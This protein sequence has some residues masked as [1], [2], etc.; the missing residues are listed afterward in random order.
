VLIIA[1]L[2]QA[3][4]PTQGLVGCVIKMQGV[5][6]TSDLQGAQVKQNVCG[7]VGRQHQQ[8]LSAALLTVSPL[9][10]TAST[11]DFVTASTLTASST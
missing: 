3:E 2:N 11:I 8:T 9:R 6:N 7:F 5:I 10:S 4:L 1:R